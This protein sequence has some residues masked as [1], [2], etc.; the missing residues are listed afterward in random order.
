M[1]LFKQIKFKKWYFTFWWRLMQRFAIIFARVVKWIWKISS[2]NFW[3]FLSVQFNKF[4]KLVLIKFLF[5]NFDVRE[6]PLK[7]IMHWNKQAGKL[8]NEMT[9][10]S[11]NYVVNM[12]ENNLT[13]KISKM[14]EFSK[15]KSE[16]TK[17]AKRLFSRKRSYRSQQCLWL[18]DV[19]WFNKSHF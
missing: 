2:H 13:N 9:N 4:A 5:Y 15:W 18:Y 8:Q 12:T 6:K 1:L 11:W 10:L 19:T 16:S 14:E 7:Y 3:N 17:C